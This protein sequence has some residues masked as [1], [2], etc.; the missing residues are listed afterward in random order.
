MPMEIEPTLNRRQWL[1]GMGLLA[2]MPLSAARAAGTAA[3]SL[4]AAWM[5]GEQMR[6][7]IVQPAAQANGPLQ[8]LQSLDVPTRAHGMA[9]LRDG[10][11]VFASRRPGDW[12]V[13][14]R[15]GQP[16]DAAQWLW[17]EPDRVFNGHVI[18][19]ADGRH[20]Y[21]TET[22]LEDAQG[23]IGVRDAATLEK[24]AE[25][26]T[27]GMD[28]HQLLLDGDG[29]LMV[30]NGGIP[31]QSETGRRKLQLDHM[32]SSIARL[33]PAE[34]GARAGLWKL[35][36]SRLSL[37]HLAWGP[38]VGHAPGR[39]WL[40]IALQ[41]EHRDAQARASAPVLALFDG[42]RLHAVPLPQGRGPLAGYGGDI[43]CDGELFAVSCPRVN[44]VTWW[45]VPEGREARGRWLRGDAMQGVYCV[46]NTSVSL[47]AGGRPL[48]AESALWM[49]GTR[50]AQLRQRGQVLRTAGAQD[51]AL[52]NH[53]IPL[54]R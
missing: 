12:L 34:G 23:L 30:A 51:M 3:G 29:T 9:A 16:A 8:V 18:E 27:G 40:G 44:T 21:T 5:Q 26:R 39:R 28:P 49:G 36:D 25:W 14:L 46:A 32:D 11:V 53:W 4:A 47:D 13:R 15:P 17:I 22:D 7:G 31:T 2:A 24:I 54:R 42:E 48:P 35:D 38:E 50:Q 52:D 10:S 45:Q 1:H 43:G 33:L 20:L 37:R 41:A 19:S 6:V